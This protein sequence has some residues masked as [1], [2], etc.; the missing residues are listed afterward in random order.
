MLPG[1][2]TPKH[3]PT[4]LHPLPPSPLPPCA[5]QVARLF[6]DSNALIVRTEGKARASAAPITAPGPAATAGAR[7]W[8]VGSWRA[9]SAPCAPRPLPPP[10]PAPSCCSPA[11]ARGSGSAPSPPPPPSQP[12]WWCLSCQQPAHSWRAN[13]IPTVD[14]SASP[15]ALAAP[16]VV[17]VNDHTASASEILAGAL[18]DNCRA[19][20]AGGRTYGKGLIQVGCKDRLGQVPCWMLCWVGGRAARGSCR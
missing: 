5:R 14:A 7:A 19:V 2:L 16:L 8:G 17:L 15:P 12:R 11:A 18:R 6:L 10:R 13:P 4:A 3:P 1:R 20:L 9:A